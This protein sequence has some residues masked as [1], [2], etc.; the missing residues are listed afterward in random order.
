MPN[1]PLLWS[2]RCAPGWPTAVAPASQL[3]APAAAACRARFRLRQIITHP[4][5]IAL[6]HVELIHKGVGG[7]P[8]APGG[9]CCQP[10]PSRTLAPE[11]RRSS[12]G[13]GRG[14]H[15]S[16]PLCFAAGCRADALFSAGVPAGTVPFLSRQER[17]PSSTRRSR[18]PP[19]AG[20]ALRFSKTAAAA[21]PHQ[22]WVCCSNSPRRNPAAFCDARVTYD[23]SGLMACR[24]RCPPNKRQNAARSW[25]HPAPR[26]ERRASQ[27]GAGCRRL[28]RV[29]QPPRLS[30]SAGTRRARILVGRR[31]SRPRDELLPKHR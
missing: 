7:K 3:L 14:V 2:L 16:S 31:R 19:A 20:G 27:E 17:S 6:H 29:P 30:R 8:A 13:G 22:P 12:R 18:P 23:R 1:A 11:W 25:R 15:A 10:S 4:R 28:G 5:R 24:G 9:R 26:E 21:E